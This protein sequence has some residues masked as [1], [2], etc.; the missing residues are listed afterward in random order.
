MTRTGKTVEPQNGKH[1][2]LIQLERALPYSNGKKSLLT[3]YTREGYWGQSAHRV[4]RKEIKMNQWI[5]K[6]V[7]AHWVK[8]QSTFI[9]ALYLNQLLKERQSTPN[10]CATCSPLI[11]C[12]T[13][14]TTNFAIDQLDKSSSWI[15][16]AHSF[17]K[18]MISISRSSKNRHILKCV[19][20]FPHFAQLN[21]TKRVSEWAK[22]CRSLWLSHPS[23]ES[24]LIA[25]S[26]YVQMKWNK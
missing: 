10:N 17:V 1:C 18:S 20:P 16:L 2:C 8:W 26:L 22:L 21:M 15:E 6:I 13:F 14:T 9:E 19:P 7:W 3:K 11:L 5:G 25:L 4:K 24:L 23:H 12:I